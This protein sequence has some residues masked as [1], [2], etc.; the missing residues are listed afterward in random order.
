MG[1]WW[2]LLGLPGPGPGENPPILFPFKSDVSGFSSG[3]DI[4]PIC[5]IRDGSK[6]KISKKKF[7]KNQINKNIQIFDI[8]CFY[9]SKK[10]ISTKFIVKIPAKSLF[11]QCLFSID[12]VFFYVKALCKQHK[13][14]GLIRLFT[15][16][17]DIDYCATDYTLMSLLLSCALISFVS[18]INIFGN[19][20]SVEFLY[21]SS[22]LVWHFHFFFSKQNKKHSKFEKLN[23][24]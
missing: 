21:S 22:V 3:G 1:I 8:K 24:F 7:K 17:Y 6:T 19:M 16:L 15:R 9:T 14:F 5:P 11:N 20:H 2:K 4:G 23:W 18:F 10:R 12:L 13:I